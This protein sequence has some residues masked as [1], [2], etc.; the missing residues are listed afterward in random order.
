MCTAAK[1]L[2]FFNAGMNSSAISGDIP[3]S[4]DEACIKMGVSPY[5]MEEILL[6]E[7][8]LTGEETMV[9]YRE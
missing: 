3:S 7:L 2:E 1:L 8:G 5:S 9:V 6:S 4:F